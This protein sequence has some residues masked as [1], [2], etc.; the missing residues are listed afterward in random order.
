MFP[1]F[2]VYDTDLSI[3]SEVECHGLC[4]SIARIGVRLFGYYDYVMIVPP[5][6]S[7][8][9]AAVLSRWG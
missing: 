2:L 8:L 9:N 1:F 4:Y 6:D 5:D 3:H 7:L